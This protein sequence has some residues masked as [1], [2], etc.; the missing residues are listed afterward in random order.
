MSDGPKRANLSAGDSGTKE[1]ASIGIILLTPDRIGPLTVATVNEDV[2][3]L[4]P[5]FDQLLYNIVDGR[6]C[7]Y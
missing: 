1:P 2:L 4:D 7:L 6:S 5:G 3:L